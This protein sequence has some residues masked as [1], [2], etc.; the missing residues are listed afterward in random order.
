MSSHRLPQINEL[1]RQELGKLFLKEMDF[2]KGYLVT[3]TKVKTS[4][5]LGQAKVLLSILPDSQEKKIITSLNKKAGF[6]KFKLGKIFVM[7]KI[8]KLIFANDPTQE[9][10][11]HIDQLIDKIHQQG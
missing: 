6:F 8:P 4:A 10:I 11:D 5:D 7:Y 9:K 3:I 2:P 1:I